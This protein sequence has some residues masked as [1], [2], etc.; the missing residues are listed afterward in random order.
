MTL[1]ESPPARVKVLGPSILGPLLRLHPPCL[2]STVFGDP[3]TL[4]SPAR[5]SLP[6]FLPCP[7]S[8]SPRLRSAPWGL[9]PTPPPLGGEPPAQGASSPRAELAWEPAVW[10]QLRFTRLLPLGANDSHGKCV[11]VALAFRLVYTRCSAVNPTPAQIAFPVCPPFPLATSLSCQQGQTPACSLWAPSPAPRPRHGCTWV[12]S[13]LSSHG[14][15]VP[16][17]PGA[18]LA[19]GAPPL[20]EPA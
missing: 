16:C 4:L 20:A 6:S 9:P 12:L 10:L 17:T 13:F 5:L 19:P 1:K 8:C 18:P 7:P 11:S 2:L 14:L 3:R 15:L